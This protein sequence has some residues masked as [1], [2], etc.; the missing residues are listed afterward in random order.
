V[1][2]R[3]QG[4]EKMD[5][6]SRNEYLKELQQRYFQTRS[7]KEKSCILDE[8]CR[9]TRQNRKHAISKINSSLSIVPRRTKKRKEIYDGY[10]KAALAKVWE[11]FDY[12]FRAKTRSSV[13]ERGF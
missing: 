10:V 1:R 4:E 13:K 12:P 3:Y 6:H 9:N 7:R 2:S 5:M 8:Y 11:I